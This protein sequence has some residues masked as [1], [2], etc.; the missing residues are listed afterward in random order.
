MKLSIKEIA[1]RS[2]RWVSPAAIPS[3]PLNG[4]S[5][6]SR[7]INAGELFVAIKGERFDGH[8]YVRSALQSG[9]VAAL[10]N[11]DWLS[12]NSKDFADASFL[13]ADDVLAA[14]QDIAHY[15]RKKINP[16]VVA[17]TGSAGKTTCKEFIYAVL[18]QKQ[19]VL[20]NQKSFNNHIGVPATLLQ[21]QPEHDILVA[22]LG[23]SDFGEIKRLSRLVEPDVR[24]ILNIGYA[25]LEFFKSL[26]GVAKAKMEIFDHAA[27]DD[28]AIINADD[29]MLARQ[30]YTKR[31][32]IT[33][34]VQHDADVRAE[35]VR[36]DAFGRYSFDLAGTRIQLAIPGRHNI[37]N[38]LAAAA[39]GLQFDVPAADIKRGIEFVDFV[40]HRMNVSTGAG[41]IIIDDVYNANPG[42]CRAALETAADIKIAA[43]GRRIAV[44]GDMLELG[45]F[46]EVEHE[47]LA[48]AAKNNSIDVLFLYGAF[49]K[50]TA[51]RA[52][53]L[54]V[55]ALH[56]NDLEALISELTIFIAP[57]DLILVKGSRSMHMERVVSALTDD[58]N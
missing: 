4:I 57:N 47:K 18:S 55:R 31:N 40:E 7:R 22:E 48:D 46:S 20:R 13:A 39:V 24:L 27:A 49:S 2:A 19:R 43:G 14:Y 35:N 32:K 30:D 50:A 26:A 28:P 56:F 21:L 6:D 58:K 53:F 1:G 12:R 36:C 9:A 11:Q 37:Y 42:S 16:R 52:D 3:D 23:A 51:A 25:H 34:A 41:N 38:A 44:L 15:Y 33:F 8:E 29:E 45:E 17:L 10:V 5:T 54:G